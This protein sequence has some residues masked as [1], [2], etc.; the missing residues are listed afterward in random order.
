[1]S[2]LLPLISPSPP[3]LAH[4]FAT[5]I[6]LKQTE[7][8]RGVLVLLRQLSSSTATTT[9]YSSCQLRQ[10]SSARQEASVNPLELEC[11]LLAALGHEVKVGLEAACRCAASFASIS[12]VFNI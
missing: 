7:C 6:A 4:A 9:A 2:H 3:V 10:P 5:H 8:A 12:L 1:M 11:E